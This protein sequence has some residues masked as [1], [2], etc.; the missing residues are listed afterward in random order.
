VLTPVS[1]VP[2]ILLL[3]GGFAAM[4]GPVPDPAIVLPCVDIVFAAMLEPAPDVASCA[5]P[6]P[7]NA[8]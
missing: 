6:E 8:D 1:P 2:A 3:G 7:A 5:S 4:L